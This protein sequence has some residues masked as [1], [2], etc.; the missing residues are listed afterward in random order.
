MD[1][2]HDHPPPDKLRRF[3]AGDLPVGELDQL[4]A[5]VEGCA[6]CLGALPRHVPD[7]PLV[8]AL[9][10]PLEPEAHA[11]EPERARF[12]AAIACD[13]PAEPSPSEVA[14]ADT[15][16]D[17]PSPSGEAANSAAP[18]GGVP[19]PLLGALPRRF[20]RYQ[21]QERLGQGGMGAVYRARDTTLDRPVAL[22]VCLPGCRDDRRAAERFLREARAAAGLQHEGICRVLDFGAVEGTHYLTMEFIQ[23]R[24]LSALLH[25]GQP[26]GLRRAAEL[27]RQV[28]RALEA[29]HHQGVI[30]R[31]L[32]PA[33]IMLDEHDRPKVVD[34]GLARREQDPVLTRA[35]T[36]VG[37]PAYMSPEQVQTGTVNASTDIYSLGVILYQLLAGRLPF[38]GPTWSQFVYQIVH[39]APEPPS[40][41][42]PD[43]DPR[44][45]AI[46]LKAMA[47][48]VPDRYAT[49]GDF[50]ATLEAYL[51]SPPS[52]PQAAGDSGLMVSAASPPA[53]G[54]PGRSR[55]SSWTRHRGPIVA[56]GVA[57][58]SLALAW[59]VVFRRPGDAGPAADPSSSEPARAAAPAFKGW[60]DVR[61]WEPG[62]ARRRDLG[63]RDFGALPLK[64]GDQVRVAA[65]MNRPA[66]LYVLWI[67][68]EGKVAPVYPWKPGR[69]DERPA[70]EQPVDRLSLPAEADVGW[71]V[72]ADAPGMETL[73]L[74]AREEP[75]P[76]GVDLRTLLADL[77][78][79][80]LKDPRAAV[81]FENGSVVRDEA[82]RGANFFD[83]QA[84]DDPVLR[85]QR[86]LQEKLQPY[87]AY[88]RA[89]SF[90]NQGR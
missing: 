9:R 12:L 18:T 32:K 59:H 75:L 35:G 68:P 87:S 55:A 73:V 11:A 52:A 33:N 79:Q 84:I 14:A 26:V 47:K 15:T 58:L 86:L 74:L 82:E 83:A 36:A 1:R 61:I 4:A 10:R 45:E 85:T 88:S 28:A 69:W 27:V 39:R 20:G 40:A 16:Q 77:P 38:P 3:L 56:A 30:H 64:P 57:I 31:D 29:A 81:W 67:D 41:H 51:G 25:A 46:C 37:T 19:D 34:F 50:A 54:S 21:V 49:M 53:P 2:T 63:L 78:R 42:R 22:K 72:T 60:I 43:L 80:A 13:L 65:R 66:Y 7:D 6:T 62:N 71:P 76:A 23:G 17:S 24:P 44:L 8:A 5:H 48:A 89:V 70:E 90:A